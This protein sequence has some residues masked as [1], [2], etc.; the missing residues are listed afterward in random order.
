VASN[1]F[2]LISHSVSDL[3]IKKSLFQHDPNICSKHI[4][5]GMDK[6]T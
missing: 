4:F 6:N 2:V 3:K 1:L 5:F